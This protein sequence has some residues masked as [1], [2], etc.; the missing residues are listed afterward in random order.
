MTNHPEIELPSPTAAAR[1]ASYVR[2]AAW[3]IA[4]GL[5]VWAWRRF[6]G[7][8]AHPYPWLTQ[9]TLGYVA[10]YALWMLVP[11]VKIRRGLVWR[12]GMIGMA[13]LSFLFVFLLIGNIMVDAVQAGAAGKKLG[14]PGLEG[15]LLFLCLS[16]LPAMLFE[17][18]PEWMQ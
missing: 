15:T 3:P 18:H 1:L 17:R 12:I 6:V 11:W 14:V 13:A 7:V 8:E 9:L 10:L 5:L 16:Q 2:L 4:L